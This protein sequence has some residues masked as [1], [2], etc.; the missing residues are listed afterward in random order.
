MRQLWAL[1]IAL[2][3]ESCGAI[4]TADVM[5]VVDM[6]SATPGIQ[7]TVTAPP[8]ASVVRRIGVQV[9]DPDGGHSLWGVGFIGGLDRG[10]AFGHM[11]RNQNIGRVTGLVPHAGCPI[12]PGNSQELLSP[13]HQPAFDGP[14]VQY[15]EGGAA[16][17]AAIRGAPGCVV[18]TVDVS[19][20]NAQ[21]GDVFDF[22][23]LDMVSIWSNHT[24]GAFS[25]A[26]GLSLDT[27]G[28]AV[29]DQTLSSYGVDADAPI[30][31]PPA[32]YRVD[33]VD[34]TNNS[35]ARI[36]VAPPLGAG[37]DAASAAVRFLPVRPDPFR[38]AAT[39]RFELPRETIVDV[40]VADAAGRRV[41]T[42]AAS[43]PME[44]GAHALVWDGRDARGAR[45]PPGLYLC[46]L[47]AGDAAFVRHVVRLR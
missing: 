34:G 13:A 36:I 45:V 37:S 47:V 15:L 3:I 6:D 8:G 30:A 18:F 17:P 24:H 46:R 27:G 9:Y 33:F 28:D 19:L 29:P 12:N 4:A 22:Y 25:T 7:S 35:P 39:L 2:A 10:I 11:T 43:L 42:L 20:D 41:R 14:E 31:V 1:V 5:V 16:A 40:E 23:V 26:A 21:P 32:A 38:D 44:A